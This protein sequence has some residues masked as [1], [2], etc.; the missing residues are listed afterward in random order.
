M[1]KSKCVCLWEQIMKNSLKEVPR[2]GQNSCFFSR[3][4]SFQF[5]TSYTSRSNDVLSPLTTLKPLLPPPLQMT[6]TSPPPP[7]LLTLQLTPTSPPTQPLGSPA[8]TTTKKDIHLRRVQRMSFSNRKKAE[9][10]RFTLRG[11]RM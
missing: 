6:P 9:R 4:L 7:P 2:R 1:T 5:F 8:I 3:D 11:R 10:L